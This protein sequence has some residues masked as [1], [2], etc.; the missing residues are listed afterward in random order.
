MALGS[1]IKCQ[2]LPLSSFSVAFG[3]GLSIGLGAVFLGTSKVYETASDISS[4]VIS[5]K[6]TISTTSTTRTS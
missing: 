6:N 2:K 5:N 3:I 4:N 1:E